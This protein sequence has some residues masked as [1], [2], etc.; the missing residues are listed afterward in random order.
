[1]RLLWHILLMPRMLAILG[2]IPFIAL[3]CG[4]RWM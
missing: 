3:G 1:M 4:G 2:S